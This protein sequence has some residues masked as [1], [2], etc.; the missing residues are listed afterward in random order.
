MTSRIIPYFNVSSFSFS[1]PLHVEE[2]IKGNDFIFI[3]YCLHF[4]FIVTTIGD[5]NWY[6]DEMKLLLPSRMY[7]FSASPS[8][9]SSFHVISSSVSFPGNSLK[10]QLSGKHTLLYN[11]NVSGMAGG[12]SG[13]HIRLPELRRTYC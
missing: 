12:G 11:I 6:Y 4:S 8:S 5:C 13:W 3:S 9:S 10:T 2:V 7:I 1:S